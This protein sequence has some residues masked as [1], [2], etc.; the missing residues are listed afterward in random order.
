MIFISTIFI[1]KCTSFILIIFIFNLLLTYD[2]LSE[3]I[4]SFDEINDPFLEQYVMDKNHNIK[5]K[6]CYDINKED[7]SINSKMINKKLD[8]Y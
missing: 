7:V 3:N 4:N 1:K 8:I 2:Y 6:I 5:R